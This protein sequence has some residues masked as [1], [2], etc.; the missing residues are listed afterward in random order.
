[1]NA[2]KSIKTNVLA[3]VEVGDGGVKSAGNSLRVRYGWMEV[4]S[5]YQSG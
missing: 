1:M 2:L 5:V 4:G 3:M